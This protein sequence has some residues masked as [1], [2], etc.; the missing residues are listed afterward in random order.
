MLYSKNSM[1]VAEK[2]HPVIF[3]EGDQDSSRGLNLSELW[4]HR[5]LLFFMTWRDISLR[6]K[7][8]ALGGLWALIYPLMSVSVF[9]IFFG[10]IA[11]IPSDGIP[12]GLFSLSGLLL[13]IYFANTISRC[14]SSL[15]GNAHMINKVYFPRLLLPLSSIFP[16]FVD[17]AI[18]S[19]ILIFGFFFY[20]IAPPLTALIW[21]PVIVLGTSLLSLGIGMVLGAVNVRYRD[22]NNG[23]AFLLQMWMFATPVVYP[24]SLIQEKYRWLVGLNPMVGYVEAFRSALYN[25]P[26]D[27]SLVWISV[28]ITAVSLVWGTRY[29]LK[30]EK[31][32]ADVV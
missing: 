27:M 23:I 18:A 10:R 31:T 1:S 7:Q 6:Y 16:G 25:T 8:T 13:W 5:E 28:A 21:C 9:T 26:L 20:R 4:R 3:I 24:A 19:L 22:I 2:A 17:F 30:M 32:F 11:Q 12:Y 15:V 14:S 29:F